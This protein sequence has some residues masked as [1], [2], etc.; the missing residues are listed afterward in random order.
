MP[1]LKKRGG[2]NRGRPASHEHFYN[3]CLWS[4][5]IE[6]SDFLDKKKKNLFIY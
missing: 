6:N 4:A 3:C 5:E 2:L 1:P